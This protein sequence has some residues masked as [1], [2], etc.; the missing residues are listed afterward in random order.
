M[1]L[2]GTRSST[3]KSYQ[4]AW[5]RWSSWCAE[6]KI[7]PVSAPLSKI[8]EFLAKTFSDSLEYHSINVLH[9]ATSSTH[10]PI[11]SFSVGQHPHVTR[12]IKGILN[13]HPPKPRYSHTWNVKKA[14]AH[15]TSLGSN[16][17]LSVKQFSRKLEICYYLKK[18]CAVRPT[19]P[20]SK[21][22]PLFISY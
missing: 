20:C 16:S 19:L 6:G 13:F 2:S 22:D 10:L 1:L 18:S 14:T 5:S 8:L 9:S 12:L 4:S 17:S 3:H 7:N 15:L 11:D 21:P